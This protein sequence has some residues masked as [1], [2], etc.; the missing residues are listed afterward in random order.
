MRKILAVVIGA[1]LFS[2]LYL[3]LMHVLALI[4]IQEQASQ[5]TITDDGVAGGGPVKVGMGDM[6]S[7]TVTRQRWYGKIIEQAGKE[8]RVSYLYLFWILKMP[9]AVN[10]FHFLYLHFLMLFLLIV[11][12]AFILRPHRSK[13]IQLRKRSLL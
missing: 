6:V 3:F 8:S 13:E 7:V 1:A 2:V 12:A 10:D 11:M 5:E 4:L 9:L